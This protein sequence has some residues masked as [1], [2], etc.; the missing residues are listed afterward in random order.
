MIDHRYSYRCSQKHN[1]LYWKTKNYD[2]TARFFLNMKID[3]NDNLMVHIILETQNIC[4]KLNFH[5]ACALKNISLTRLH[6]LNEIF[7]FHDFLSNLL[8]IIK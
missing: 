2:S 8:V 1:I 3:N 6:L 4:G 7:I 5:L